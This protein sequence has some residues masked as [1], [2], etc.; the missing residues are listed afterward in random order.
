MPNVR[1]I[2]L[3]K[4]IHNTLELVTRWRDDPGP[5]ICGAGQAVRSVAF[6][7]IDGEV[8]LELTADEL[9]EL[10]D[11]SFT[12]IVERYDFPD[13]AVRAE[14]ACAYRQIELG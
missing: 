14:E 9:A 6:D 1:K 8:K 4:V 2:I 13:A 5:A 12:N 10:A 3:M 7:E 11:S